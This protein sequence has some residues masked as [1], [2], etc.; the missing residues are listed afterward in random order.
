MAAVSSV[1]RRVVQRVG[2]AL[3]RARVAYSEGTLAALRAGPV[4]V[5]ANHVSLIDGILIALASPV[6]MVYAV[7]TEYSRHSWWAARGLAALSGLGL[8]RVLPLDAESPHGIRSLSRLLQAGGIVM[9]FPEGRISR[10][11]LAQPEQP[12]LEWL[13]RRTG[14]RVVS[15]RIEGAEK[16]MLFAK[17]GTHLWPA[18]RIIF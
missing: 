17:A 14:A 18:V 13:V 2:L 8:G 4:I 9:V 11:G 5:T 1:V 6:H 10:D 15:L 3:L 16:S 12:G 7:D